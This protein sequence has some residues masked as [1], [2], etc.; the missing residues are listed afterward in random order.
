[1][2]TAPRERDQVAL[3][4]GVAGGLGG[5]IAETLARRGARLLVSDIDDEGAE[6]TAASLRAQGHD[7][8]SRA[9]DVTIGDDV[10]R[11]VADT[12]AEW[13]GI[14]ILVNLAG[15]VRN[16]LFVKLDDDD[17]HLTMQTHVEG[18]LNAMRAVVP[19]MR[20]QGYGRI[21]NMS[22]IAVRGS[23]AGSSYG[24][25]K[26]AI[27]GMTRAAAME[28]AP[29]G[30]TI[31]CVAPGLIDAGMFRSVPKEYQDAALQRVPMQR[32]GTAAE[33]AACVAFLASPD[34]SYVTGQTLFACGGATL[35]F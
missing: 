32:A 5:A 2:T 28:L 1:M 18:V 17:F 20:E 23:I 31:N 8:Q 30:V 34:A 26:A 10:Q 11:V 21:V 15:V 3:V 16:G 29:D 4:T 14:D 27:E 25:A 13:G 33:V 9:L 7:V 24:A 22:S 19:G 12:Q 35:G 6:R